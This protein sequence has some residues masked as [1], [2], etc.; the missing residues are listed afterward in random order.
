M[1]RFSRLE[2]KVIASDVTQAVEAIKAEEQELRDAVVILIK[3]DAE[4]LDD[5]ERAQDAVT[6]FENRP[7]LLEDAKRFR[8]ALR[9]G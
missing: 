2:D 5:I 3:E 8:D 6:V 7:C 9:D 1:I 4:L